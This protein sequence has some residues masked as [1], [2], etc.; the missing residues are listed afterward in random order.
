MKRVILAAAV[1]TVALAAD[2]AQAQNGSLTRSFV[3]ST[4]V[5]TNP[6][7]ITQPCGS[8][9][10]AYTKI[11]ANGIIA[12][13]DPGK[14]GPLTIIGPV[15]INGNG[16]AAITGL[17]AGSAITINAGSGNV[18]LTGLELDGAGA[19]YNGIVFNSGGSLT[20]TDC[21]VENFISSGPPTTGNGILMQPTS[22]TF[23]FAIINTKTSNNQYVG[24][25]YFPPTNNS[26]ETANG[27]I[28]HV[29][30]TNN[31][32]RISIF[33][34]ASASISISNSIASNNSGGITINGLSSLAVSIDNS[35][36]SNN[37]WG[38][39]SSSSPRVLLGRSVIT[40]NSAYGIDNEM[41]PSTFY[42][43]QNNQINLNGNSNQVGGS[44]L[45]ALP[46][47]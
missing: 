33:T 45:T 14:Y 36:M 20:V 21:V 27:V 29:I 15:T 24:V 18:T 23:S 4:G 2:P 38:I 8:F 26:T 1:L 28:D 6:C 46:F 31:G 17:A 7:T 9:A 5:D 25:Y 30:A 13:L 11:S 22:G 32:F 37:G 19:S 44:A 47:Q 39:L 3:S 16:W 10:V 35:N 12:A 43:Y 34:V 40:S 42:T 41:S